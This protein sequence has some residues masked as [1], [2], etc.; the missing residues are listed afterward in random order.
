MVSRIAV[1]IAVA[2]TLTIISSAAGLWIFHSHI[3]PLVGLAEK[4]SLGDALGKITY[5]RYELI[6]NG[7][8]YKVEIE[9]EPGARRGVAHLIYPNGT[10]VSYRYNYTSTLVFLRREGSN[11]TLNPLLYTEAFATSLLIK[12]DAG[13]VEPFPG[14]AP[15]FALNYIGNATRLDWRALYDP[16]AE[17][18][19]QHVLYEFQGVKVGREEHRGLLLQI[20]ALY[21]GELSPALK[22]YAVN[23][24]AKVA[25]VGGLVIAS[26]ISLEFTLAGSPYLVEV[27]LEEVRQ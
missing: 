1:L 5:L 11:V 22:W 15:I 2:F 8:A 18:R 9:N 3:S 10:R 13:F 19:P 17:V 12:A 26:E 7:E 6:I 25:R 21:E 27:K 24:V 20:S 14:I 4:R 23:C 16:K